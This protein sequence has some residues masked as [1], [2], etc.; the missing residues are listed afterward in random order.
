[1]QPPRPVKYGSQ[2]TNEMGELWFQVLAL[3]ASERNK[4]ERDFYAHLARLAIDYNEWRLVEDPKNAEAHTRAGRARF[5]FGEV[6]KALEH[7]QA[8]I[9]ADSKYDRAYYELGFTYLRQNKLGEA[10]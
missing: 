7:Y 6:D 4:F 5:F 2:T 1:N 3:N 10:K 8:A 9:E